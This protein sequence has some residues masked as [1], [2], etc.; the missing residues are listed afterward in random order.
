MNC[1]PPTQGG[2]DALPWATLGRPVGAQEKSTTENPMH[3]AINPPTSPT[4]K[5]KNPTPAPS[6]PTPYPVHPSEA[7]KGRPK[8]AQGNALGQGSPR[9]P[10][11]VGAKQA[12]NKQNQTDRQ[13]LLRPYRARFS[14]GPLTQGSAD[15][16]P[17]A[18]LGRPVGAQDNSTT[19]KPDAQRHHPPNMTHPKT[20]KSNPGNLAPNPVP[21]PPFRSPKGAKCDSPG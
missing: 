17:W 4:Q 3:N 5:Q 11:P 16:L 19:E 18:T 20:G 15:A 10:S 6:H 7:P 8:V 21:S 12:P 9:K 13:L 1:E 14:G 2:A